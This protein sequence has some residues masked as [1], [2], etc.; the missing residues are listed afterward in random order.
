MERMQMTG[1][2]CENCGK[3]VDSIDKFC[4]YCGSNRFRQINS[5]SKTSNSLPT[6]ASSQNNNLVHHLL[7]WGYDGYYVFS[8]TKFISILIVISFA[9]SVFNG[10]PGAIAVGLILAIFL[11]LIGFCVRKILGKPSDIVLAHND[12]GLIV[13]LKNAFLCW[14]NK[15]TGEFVYSKTKIL[16]LLIFFAV[17]FWGFTLAPPYFAACIVLGLLIAVPAYVIGFIIHSLTNNNPTPKRVATKPKPQV[18]PK[19]TEKKPEVQV[20]PKVVEKDSEFKIYQSQLDDLR[21]EYDVKEKRL[22]DLIAKRFEPPQ[23][24]YNK[25]ISAVDNST[26]IFNEKADSIQSIIDLATEDSKRIDDEIKSR[27]DILKSLISKIDDLTDELVLNMD[28]SGDENVKD[29]LD[30]MNYLIDSVKDYDNS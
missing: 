7:Y 5:V 22:R 25:F 16:T 15:K 13:D 21:E 24:T 12:Y 6:K 27:M 26:S 29:L 23:L 18:T 19:V 30:D 8:K 28:K 2:V 14:Q 11:Y 1:K 17:T 20:T 3:T 4:P 9:L 10:Y